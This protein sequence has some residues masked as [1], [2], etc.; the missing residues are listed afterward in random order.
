MDLNKTLQESLDGLW[1]NRSYGGTSELPRKD[2]QPYSASSGYSYPYQQGGN[3]MFP[4]TSPDPQNTLS[5]PWPMG[6]VT[7]DL[8]DGFVYILSA[9]KKME[10][11]LNENPS[12][13]PKQK[14]IL[15]KYIK[16]LKAALYIVKKIGK[17]VINSV[18]LAKDLPPQS[19]TNS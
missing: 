6:N 15:K 5:V 13:K 7:E 11:C 9:L 3:T 14:K 2:Y 1:G 19:P 17:S 18:N 16:F 4:P 8:A 12:L 10:R